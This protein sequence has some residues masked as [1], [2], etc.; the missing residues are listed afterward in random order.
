M[1]TLSTSFYYLPEI[2]FFPACFYL[3]LSLTA[4][5]KIWKSIFYRKISARLR[6]TGIM[7][8]KVTKPSDNVKANRRRSIGV[9]SDATLLT[10]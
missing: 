2:F 4:T 10:P 9:V 1:N 8:R 7:S 6:F 5:G 3:Y